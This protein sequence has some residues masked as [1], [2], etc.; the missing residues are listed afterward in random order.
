MYVR[1]NKRK[2]TKAGWNKKEGLYLS[3]VLVE[4]YREGDKTRQKIIKYL[5]SIGE[6]RIIR[7]WRRRDFWETVEKNLS[8]VE[9]SDD[10]RLK[11]IAHIEKA[12]PRPTAS[13][14]EADHQNNLRAMKEIEERLRKLT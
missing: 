1:W 3:A 6:E 5:G 12:V 7:V 2:R 13:D 10:E 4:G 11:I 8:L 9:M 14:I